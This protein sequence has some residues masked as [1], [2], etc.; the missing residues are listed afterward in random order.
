MPLSYETKQSLIKNLQKYIKDR[1]GKRDR[2]CCGFFRNNFGTYSKKEK[3]DAANILIDILE[4][5]RYSTAITEEMFAP[6][7]QGELYNTI[8]QSLKVEEKNI[9]AYDL[10]ASK[11]IFECLIDDKPPNPTPPKSILR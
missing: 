9:T 1:D 7:Q 4:G 5:K 2:G 6:L 3:I 11:C 10:F 8:N